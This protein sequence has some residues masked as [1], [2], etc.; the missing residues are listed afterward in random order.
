MGVCVDIYF[1]LQCGDLFCLQ[2][3][4]GLYF[5]SR[6]RIYLVCSAFYLAR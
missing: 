1:G 3:G 5:M 6:V 4:P 2:S